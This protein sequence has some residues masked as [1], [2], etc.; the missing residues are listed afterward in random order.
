MS[1]I[2]LVLSCLAAFSLLCAAQKRKNGGGGSKKKKGNKNKNAD[3]EIS[4]D[5]RF[6]E[7]SGHD[8]ATEEVI[9]NKNN[10]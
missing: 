4:A 5:L 3:A 8:E 2:V 10:N 1:R 9:T 7:D 6:D